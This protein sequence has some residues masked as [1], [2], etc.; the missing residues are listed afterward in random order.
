MPRRGTKHYRQVW[1]EEDASI[2]LDNHQGSD[3]FPANQPRGSLDQMDDDIAE[4]DQV[5]GGPLLNRLLSSMKFEN[6][7]E[8]KEKTNGMTN[9][10]SLANGLTNGDLGNEHNS[11][12]NTDGPPPATAFPESN[13]PGWKAPVAKQD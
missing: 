10:E 2:S 3:K 5:S 7:P 4:T 6:R 9:G 11:D 1:A 8:E 12:A 13:T